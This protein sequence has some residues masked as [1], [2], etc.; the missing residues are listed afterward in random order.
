[1]GALQSLDTVSVISGVFEACCFFPIK[2]KG[3]VFESCLVVVL[4]G[5]GFLILVFNITCHLQ[6]ELNAVLSK[7]TCSVPVNPHQ[8][9]NGKFEDGVLHASLCNW[10][11]GS[12]DAP[13]LF[14][15]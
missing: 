7:L 14:P 15:W 13:Q 10:F 1:M 3:F 2:C 6:S 11:Q 8:L 9:A 5:P 4:L 12:L